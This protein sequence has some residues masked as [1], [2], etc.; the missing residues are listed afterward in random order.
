MSRDAV[1]GGGGRR[2]QTGAVKPIVIVL[3]VVAVLAL[4]GLAWFLT[5]G[6]PEQAATG[7][8]TQQQQQVAEPVEDSAEREVQL[9]EAARSALREQRWFAPPGDNA[10]ELYLDLL[11]IQPNDVSAREA[12]SESMPY[13]VLAAERALAARDHD[14][15]ERLIAL[16]RRADERAPSLGRL[17]RELTQARER[18]ERES[19]EQERVAR[20]PE[21][22]PQP[23]AL[24]PQ[25]EPQPATPPPSQPVATTPPPQPQTP[26][27]QT[28]PPPAAPAQ[29]AE[30][31]VGVPRVVSR[32][33]PRYPPQ[34]LRRR[35][36]GS[37]EVEFTINPDGS[38]SDAT[39]VR[40]SSGVFERDAL[41]AVLGWRFEAP[42]AEVRTR[43]T[44]DFKLD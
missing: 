24:P 6:E 27:P 9:R 13:A 43:Q 7:P 19:A 16:I 22:E 21:P 25:P 40:S 37:V 38:V 44:I 10:M 8:G 4:G 23:V 36:E 35:L 28:Q 1:F 18:T 29:P 15:T 30:P 3:V 2:W 31:P 42:G 17:E 26:P 41:R 11:Q 39:V 5:R 14:E 32:S 33:A 12:V 20:T 34:A